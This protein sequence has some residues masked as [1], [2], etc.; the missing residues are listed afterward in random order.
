MLKTIQVLEKIQKIDLEIIAVE[1]EKKRY[2]SEIKGMTE[3]LAVARQALD[4]MAAEVEGIRSQVRAVDDRIGQNS[5]KVEKDEKRLNDIKNTKELNAL[6][7]EISGANKS[8][9]LGEQEKASLNARVDEKAGVLNGKEEAFKAKSSELERLTRAV[10]EKTP[11]WQEAV[12][13]NTRLRDEIKAGI[14]PEILKKYE[15]IRAKR[16][17]QGIALVK[18]ET[19]QGCYIH[20]PPQVYIILKRGAD[21]LMFCPHCHRI[22]YVETPGPVEAV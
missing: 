9:K 1:E 19:C 2:A 7:K 5:A 18:N 20:I 10:E 8:R 6:T 21:E 15:T 4:S 16:G 17:G 12:E 22:L 11:E 13:K 14:R 3:E